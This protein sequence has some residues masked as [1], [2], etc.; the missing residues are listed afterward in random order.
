MAGAN[1]AVAAKAEAL[2]AFTAQN[3]TAS[4]ATID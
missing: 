4:A 2:A 3:L 1:E